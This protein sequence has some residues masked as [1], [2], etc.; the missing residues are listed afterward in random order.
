MLWPLGALL[1]LPWF[2]VI[3]EALRGDGFLNR[4]LGWVWHTLVLGAGFILALRLVP[5]LFV[6]ILMLPVLPIVNGLL[7]LASARLRGSWVFAIG[8]AMFMSW[9]LLAVFPMA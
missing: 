5:E 6:L 4:T 3:G 8:G 9:V 7:E 2:L 1:S